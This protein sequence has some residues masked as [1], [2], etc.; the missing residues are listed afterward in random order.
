M[1]I[2]KQILTI[3][4]LITFSISIQAQNRKYDKAY[5]TFNAGEY[6]DAIDYLKEA[7]EAI[8]NKD[9]KNQIT[10]DIAECYRKT[11]QPTK[12]ALWYSKAIRKNYSDPIIYFHYA[13]MLKMNG[14]YEEA[15]VQFQAYKEL[16]PGDSRADDGIL[17][18]DLAQEWMDF[19][20]GYNVEDIRFINSKQ[21]DFSPAFARDDY[22][23]LY[24]TS[25]REEATGSKEQGV[26]G[27]G[28]TDILMTTLDR[29]GKWSTPVPLSDNI[30]SEYDDGTPALS[31]DYNHMYFS[32]C[33]VRDKK[34]TGCGIYVAERKNED[35]S[36]AEEL[37][38]ISD[39]LL[40]THPAISNDELT[41]YFVS[42]M[43][44]SME[45]PDGK[46]SDD[47]WMVTRSSVNDDFG[48]PVNMGEPINSEGDEAFPFVHPDGTFYFAST[49][50]IGMGGYDIFKATKDESGSWK[51]ENMRYP[52]NSSS[53]DFGICFEADREAGFFSSTRS[54][55]SD[56]I[57]AFF[58]PPLKF[59]ISGVVKNEKTNEP[60]EGAQ[61]KS[62]GSDGI[63]LE[64]T[65]SNDGSFKF[66]LKPGTDYLFLAKKENYLQ[67]KER[68][69][70]KS[71]ETSMDFTT[72]IYLAPIDK[73]I[74][75]ENIF[76][77]FD[78]DVLR[79]ESMVSL[80][81][82]V[83]T[84]NDNPNITIE[85]SSHTDS[86]GNDEYNLDL[87]QARAQSVVDYLI[88]KNI[89]PDRLVAKGYGESKPKI[90]DAKDH[91]AYPFLPV[92]QELT[93]DYINSIKDD[94]LKEVA[95]FLNRRTEFF[96]LSTDYKG[97]E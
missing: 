28:F 9:A 72:E 32:R 15:K 4:L 64:T 27:Q 30:N 62:V 74:T 94:D 21:D 2:L 13:N 54:G 42:D 56:D 79:P 44:G 35:W 65:T 46:P 16:V 1:R 89:A 96:V 23:V 3:C 91:E 5:N 83:E 97:N 20:N 73:P 86:R 84:L 50:H 87:S 10:F 18:C 33:L 69:T 82:L 39:T 77:D 58:L 78:S 38:L 34:T 31:R 51:V 14:E 43:E 88:S 12:A 40:A 24:F 25:A 80:D 60:I 48:E 17:S 11:N 67:G 52:I 81:K 63:T 66:M 26:S 70:T 47:I 61:V 53:D 49:G 85:L 71:R 45:G 29:K 6:Y 55:R 37:T 57:Y 90:V 93:E 68:E 95:Y 8:T 36:K 59:T 41:L 7:Y 19:P 75:I 22:R 92:G 76:F